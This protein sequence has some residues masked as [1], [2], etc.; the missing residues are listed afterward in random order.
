MRKNSLQATIK[1]FKEELSDLANYIDDV[2]KGIDD[3]ESMF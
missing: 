3:I 2:R 1:K